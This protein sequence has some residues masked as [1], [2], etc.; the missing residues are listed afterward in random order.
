[1]HPLRKLREAGQSRSAQESPLLPDNVLFNS[2]DP[3]RG[4]YLRPIA[5]MLKICS[6]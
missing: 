4:L 5:P 3:H 1:M 6:Y 2:P